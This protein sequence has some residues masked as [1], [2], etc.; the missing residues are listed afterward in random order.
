MV[1]VAMG[2]PMPV[3]TER[4]RTLV[5]DDSPLALNR[6]CSC[7][8]SEPILQLV[9][10][11]AN[12]VEALRQAE[13]LHPD[14]VLVDLQMPGINGLEVASRLSGDADSPTVVI[15][16]GLDV[17]GLSDRLGDFGVAGL[18]S[19]QHLSEELPRLLHR[20]LPSASH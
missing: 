9:G 7:I 20:I 3:A 5:V 2:D 8:D 19:K 10:T 13:K 12:G 18:L 4:I 15:V 14:L 1:S 17:S 16:T 11:A 6:I